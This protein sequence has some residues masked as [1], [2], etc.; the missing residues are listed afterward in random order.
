MSRHY[1]FKTDV[2]FSLICSTMVRSPHSLFIIICTVRQMQS[3]MFGF[4]FFEENSIFLFRSLMLNSKY[5]QISH[6]Y[7]FVL[8]GPRH[9]QVKREHDVC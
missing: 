1:S 3:I 9:K 6:A 4:F 8:Y 5:C 2:Y 7:W